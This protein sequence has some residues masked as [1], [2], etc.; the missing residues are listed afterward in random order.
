MKDIKD[1]NIK[2]KEGLEIRNLQRFPSMEYGEDGGMKCDIYY[3]DHKICDV[4]QAGNG[5][6]A[7]ERYV[8]NITPELRQEFKQKV[9]ACLQRL[10]SSY[11]P[12]TSEYEWLKTKT[13]DHIDGDDLEAL[14]LT[15]E[16]RYEDVQQAKKIFQDRWTTLGIIDR[17]WQKDYVHCN[18]L[19]VNEFAKWISDKHPE[20]KY[21]NLQLIFNTD[22]LEIL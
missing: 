4:Y 19:S 2:T 21:K 1:L 16:D 14:E 22:N 6:C 5:G 17:E 3:H 13:A 10:D 9:L 8:D 12:A 18:F 7:D 11:N 15:I 20:I